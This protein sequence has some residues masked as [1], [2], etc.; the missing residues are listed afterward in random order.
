[1]KRASENSRVSGELGRSTRFCAG[2]RIRKEPPRSLLGEGGPQTVE[3]DRRDGHV[4][5]EGRTGSILPRHLLGGQGDPGCGQEARLIGKRTRAVASPVKKSPRCAHGR[6][7]QEPRLYVR[8]AGAIEQMHIAQQPCPSSMAE[9][10]GGDAGI[11]RRHGEGDAFQHELGFKPCLR[12]AHS[13]R[14]IPASTFC[15]SSEM[16]CQAILA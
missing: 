13:L 10:C 3:A 15:A 6:V 1:M 2:E 14:G 11:A 12:E 16:P 4:R 8:F 5:E 7:R 9:R